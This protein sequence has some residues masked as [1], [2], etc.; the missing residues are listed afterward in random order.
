M[1]EKLDSKQ[2]EAVDAPEGFEI[3]M[4]YDAAGVKRAFFASVPAAST[5]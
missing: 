2:G 5:V 3:T 1:A 4:R